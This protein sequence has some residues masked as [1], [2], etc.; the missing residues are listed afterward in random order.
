MG[1]PWNEWLEQLEAVDAGEPSWGQAEGFVDAVLAAA[2][3]KRREVTGRAA[4]DAALGALGPYS[5][6]VCY[7]E[8]EEL[9][10]WEF[11]DFLP[12]EVPAVLRDLETIRREF[13][14]WQRRVSMGS[15]VHQDSSAASRI[16]KAF[17]HARA[18][19]ESNAHDVAAEADVIQT[20]VKQV[21]CRR[22]SSPNVRYSYRQ[23]TCDRVLYFLFGMDPFRCRSCRHRFHAYLGADPGD[24]ATPVAPSGVSAGRGGGIPDED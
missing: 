3:R 17:R 5:D 9:V 10:D 8:M 4:L 21:Q 19:R 6:L 7:F 20:T 11:P 24:A 16:V 15:T 14:S 13:D 23:T 18:H 12:H 22:C 2:E 1:A